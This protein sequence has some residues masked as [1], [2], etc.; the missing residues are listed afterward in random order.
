[1]KKMGGYLCKQHFLDVIIPA[2]LPLRR[3]KRRYRLTANL[4]KLEAHTAFGFGVHGRNRF[5]SE[6]QL[7]WVNMHTKLPPSPASARIVVTGGTFDKQ[8]DAIRGELTFKQSHLPAILAQS[9]VT[10]P[11]AVEINQ[12]IDSLEM[13]DEHR[14]SVLAACRMATESCIVVIHGTDTMAQ[15]A[16]V[17]GQAMLGKTVVL[18]G[19]MIPYSVQGSDALFN[20]GFAL[21]AAQTLPADTYVAMNGRVFG[22]QEVQKNKVEGVFETR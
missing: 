21:A 13:H 7:N 11:I 14:A 19:A 6:V 12:L 9:R 5:V 20:L 17:I 10:I 8:Y 22:W 18:T 16:A 15:T 1:M 3:G 2:E 4:F